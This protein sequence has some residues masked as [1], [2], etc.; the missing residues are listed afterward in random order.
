MTTVA[1][2]ADAPRPGLVLTDLAETTP[3]SE[4]EAADCYTAMFRDVCGAIAESGADLLVNY[5]AADDLPDEFADAD[6]EAELR[7]ALGG[8]V[9]NPASV[10]FEVQVGE[11]LAG[12]VGNTVTHLLEE[13]AVNTAAAVQPTAALL[14]R[15][16][17][18]E[19]AM[20]LRRSGVTLGPAT[21]GRVYYA[22]FADPIDFDDAYAAPSVETLTDRALDEGHEVDF[23]PMLPVVED[24][25]DL[26]GALTQV[27]ARRRAGRIFPG[28]FA[29]F[30]AEAGLTVVSGTGG[31]KVVRD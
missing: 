3:L 1:V 29:E 31:L 19:A 14:G 22:G 27:R 30:C 18:D 17:V 11:T 26:A 16:Q 23:L 28:E 9:S 7:E 15:Q 8:V 5:R 2:L 25:A 20:K 21:D 13:E 4:S 10:R 6:P 24:G 12:R